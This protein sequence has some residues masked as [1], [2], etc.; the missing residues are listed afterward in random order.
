MDQ[1]INFA[2]LLNGLQF[3]FINLNHSKSSSILLSQDIV[4]LGLDVICLN[5]L[6]YTSYGI[7]YFSNY[8]C[9]TIN[10]K[11]YSTIIVVN[12]KIKYSVI[13]LDRDAI[14][15][16]IDYW[17][18]RFLLINVYSPRSADFQDT[19]RNLETLLHRFSNQNIIITGGFN[20]KHTLWGSNHNDNRG[21][22]LLDLMNVY[23]ISVLTTAILLQP[24]VQPLVKVRSHFI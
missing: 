10:D 17:N 7:T 18:K 8:G 22:M 15:I 16:S 1:K 23:N 11:P 3:G 12:R 4:R 2:S 6:Y 20:A 9:V 21:L 24:T 14:V 19:I 13:S 5:E